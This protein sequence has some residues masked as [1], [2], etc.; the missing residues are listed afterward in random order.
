MSGFPF[1]LTGAIGGGSA[2]GLIVLQTDETIEHDFRRMFRDCDVAIHVTRLASGAN[3]TADTLADMSEILPAAAALLPRGARYDVVG[4]GCTSA[5]AVIGSAK[6]AR[7]VAAA[8]N[9]RHVTDPL[10]SLL[11]ICADRGIRKLALLSPYIADVSQTLRDAL[12]AG[13]VETPVVG[14]FDEVE[15]ARVARISPASIR[16]AAIELGRSSQVDG[17][18]LSCT[19]LQTLDILAEIEAAVGKPV[20]SSNQALAWHMARLAGV[21][22]AQI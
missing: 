21:D 1:D 14:T 5:S 20:F 11:A 18:F 17:V 4:Y 6:V 8:C 10:G 9:T 12:A 7:L 16:D 19:N 13:S 2:I 15:D 22:V 3:V